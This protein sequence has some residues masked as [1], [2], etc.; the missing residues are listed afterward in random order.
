MEAYQ[1]DT[2]LSF[3]NN[4][5][6]FVTVCICV[7]IA[8]SLS[9]SLCI[10]LRTW[11]CTCYRYIDSFNGAITVRTHALASRMTRNAL[12]FFFLY[13]FN[14]T[15]SV[16]FSLFARS[17][18]LLHIL[19]KTFILPTRCKISTTFPYLLMDKTYKTS[20]ASQFIVRKNLIRYVM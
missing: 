2:K 6:F 12:M 7:C 8:L 10:Y 19:S 17:L 1:L 15:F 18:S 9:L 11:E 20:L 4:S 16:S 3:V 13:F 14:S 5:I